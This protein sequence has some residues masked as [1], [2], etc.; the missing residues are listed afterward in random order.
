[1]VK[2]CAELE[3][4]C[5]KLKKEK[6][7]LIKLTL[8]QAH[9]ISTL[10]KSLEEV[11]LMVP[12]IRPAYYRDLA[13]IDYMALK[14]ISNKQAN[15]V[16]FIKQWLNILYKCS[17]DKLKDI[18]LYGTVT[19]VIRNKLF[20]GKTA[21]PA[22]QVQLIRQSFFDRVER[23]NDNIE[24]RNGPKHFNRCFKDALRA[25]VRTLDSTDEEWLLCDIEPILEE[26]EIAE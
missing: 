24:K 21:M 7:S 8:H 15:D 1:M 26:Y 20:Q 18:S 22:E 19:R 14:N 17:L 5:E 3:Q 9:K 25:I 23:S 16:I 2:K 12:H 6:Q 11:R 13:E 10:E 4:I